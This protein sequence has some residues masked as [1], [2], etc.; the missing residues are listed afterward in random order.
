M[1][2]HK[3]KVK[4]IENYCKKN[5]EAKFRINIQKKTLLENSHE[6][7]EK[8]KST[9]QTE[10]NKLKKAFEKMGTHLESEIQKN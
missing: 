10:L 1:K 3:R 5:K 2:M 6:M 8:Y 9:L 7:K 4:F